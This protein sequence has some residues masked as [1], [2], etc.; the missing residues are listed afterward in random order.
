M[1]DDFVE[2]K[3][4]GGGDKQMGDSITCECKVCRGVLLCTG[5]NMQVNENENPFLPAIQQTLDKINSKFI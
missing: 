2:V 5:D 4:D 3:D 1:V